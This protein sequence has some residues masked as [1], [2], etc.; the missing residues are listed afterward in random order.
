MDKLKVKV[1]HFLFWNLLLPHKALFSETEIC[2]TCCFLNFRIIRARTYVSKPFDKCKSFYNSSSTSQ[3]LIACFK[4]C[5]V[6]S[7][8]YFNRVIRGFGISKM[9]FAA[10]FWRRPLIRYMN[11]Y[12]ARLGYFKAIFVD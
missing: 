10:L 3:G 7:K 9:I 12:G 6:C 8:Y 4:T 11:F 2:I 5:L 1:V